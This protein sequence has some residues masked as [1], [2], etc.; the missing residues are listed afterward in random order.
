MFSNDT[1]QHIAC[2]ACRTL[3]QLGPGGID[4]AKP[5]KRRA[6][7]SKSPPERAAPPPADVGPSPGAGL[8]V[9]AFSTL[10]VM[11]IVGVICLVFV[12]SRSEEPPAIAW[13]QSLNASSSQALPRDTQ[14]DKPHI[15]E[16]GSASE[17]AVSEK[18]GAKKRPP[19]ER[20]TPDTKKRTTTSNPPATS[21]ASLPASLASAVAGVRHSVVTITNDEG[22]QGSGFVVQKRGWVATN[23]HVVAGTLRGTAHRKCDENDDWLEIDIK[24]FVACDPR[25]DLVILALEKDWPADPLLLSGDAP[26]L[27]EDVFAI[28]APKGLTETITRGIVSQVRS[29]ADVGY[30]S[31]SPS[32][33]IIQTDAFFTNGSSGGPLC[34]AEGKVIGITSFGLQQDEQSAEFH[35][36]IAAEELAVLLGKASNFP[37]PLTELP[38]ARD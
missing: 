28:G 13:E 25:K 7:I 14:S 17:D 33:K 37:R 34:S 5:T 4:V 27:G 6:K 32:T 38:P 10:G 19:G 26:R 29:A 31:L 21:A 8:A 2:P 1:A 9:A 36:A 35:F 30:E 16:A 23:L 3:L 20:A 24:G 11:A 15:P 18:P 22:G 12:L